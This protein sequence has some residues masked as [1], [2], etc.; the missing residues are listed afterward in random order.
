MIIRAYYH[1]TESV[2]NKNFTGSFTIA[3]S[4]SEDK[5]EYGVHPEHYI[6]I[7]VTPTTGSVPLDSD[8]LILAKIAGK[9]HVREKYYFW[10]NGFIPEEFNPT[11]TITSQSIVEH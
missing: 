1:F 5:T 7:G 3:T 9:D 11:L 4:G 6:N 10:N 2:Q 8:D